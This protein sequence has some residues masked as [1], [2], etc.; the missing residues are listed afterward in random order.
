[1]KYLPL[2]WSG[3]RRR[4]V[5][6]ALIFL[7]VSVAFALFGVLQGMKTGVDQAIARVRADVL[8]VFPAVF[9]G[10]RLPL[11]YVDR[12]QSI[13]GVKTVTFADNMGGIYQE[14]SQT[15]GVLAIP[16]SKVWLTLAPRIFTIAPKA[17]EALRNTQDGAL[18]TDD[19]ARKYGWHVGEQIAIKSNIPQRSGSRVWFFDVVGNVTDREPG[20]DSLIVANY[21][22]L[23]EA[24]ASDKDT[25]RNFY[26]IVSDPKRA[27]SM[28]E[29]IDRI[30]ANSPEGT[31]T[32]SLHDSAEQ[33]MQAIGNVSFAIRWII[34][35][36]L[37]A[38]AF[39]TSTMMMQSVRE[40][41]EELAVLKAV[42]FGDRTVLFLL[43]AESLA[44]YV[45]AA[46]AGLALAWIAFPLAARYVAGLSMPISVVEL[47][48]LGAVF[49]AL[50]T[51]SVPG[52][53]AAR[54]HVAEAL[55]GR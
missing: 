8:L 1:M 5:R 28:S 16:T 14:P 25:V 52:Y 26:V 27:A 12:L 34:S 4:P 38:V 7:Q 53:R 48:I 50:V 44:V 55:A 37:I 30:F 41:T 20:Q 45:V 21:N 46:F 51:A 36:V 31:K 32:Q 47:G 35:A 42:G 9:G 33:E 23:N 43:A 6:A 10:T 40:R 39:S 22:Y 19:I 15:L 18:V 11:S 17:F 2:I 49:L 24:R 29:T 13:A 3:I 54:L